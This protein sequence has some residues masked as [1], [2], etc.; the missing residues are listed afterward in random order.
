MSKLQEWLF[1]EGDVEGGVFPRLKKLRLKGYPKLKVSLPDY[2]P[3]LK[4]I[5]IVV[6]D[7][8]LA[9]VPRGQQMDTA[10]PSLDAMCIAHCDWQELFLEGGLP[11]SLK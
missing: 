6:C 1:I 7:K 10:F 2:L 8:L 11:S 5:E 9:L 4:H 3:S